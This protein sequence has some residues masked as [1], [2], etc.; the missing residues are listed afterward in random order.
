[1][2]SRRDFLKISAMA[3]AS[4]L[5]DLSSLNALS[6]AVK[7]KNRFPVAIVGAGLGGLTCGAYLAKA[8]FPVTVLEKHHVPGG[9]ASSFQRGDFDFEV[10]L[11]AIAASNNATH[12]IFRELGLLEKIELVQLE[13][14]HRLVSRGR[15]MVLPDCNPAAYIDLLAGF[16]PAEKSGI[17]GFVSEIIGIQEEVYKLFLN[18]NRYTTIL[19]PFQYPKMWGVRNQTLQNLLDDHVKDPLLQDDLSYLCGYYGLPPSRL[20]GFYYANSVADYLKNGSCYIKGRSQ[21]LSNALVEIISEN[22]GSVRLSTPV[23]RILVKKGAVAGVTT[24]GGEHVPATFVVSNASVPDTLYK[25]LGD[26]PTL[27]E[28]RKTISALRP[29]LSS[30]CVWLGLRGSL[31]KQIKGC[32]IHIACAGSMENA[33]R[34]A[35]ECNAEKTGFSVTLFDNFYPGYSAPG[36]STVMLTCLSGYEPWRIFEKDYFSGRKREYYRQKEN[37]AVTLI[38]RTEKM[39]IPGL[40]GMIIERE[41]ATP[42]TNIAYT[43]NPGGAIYGY[44]QA[45]NNQFM[46]RI[47]NSTPIEG[48]YLSSAWGYPGG[49]FTGVMRGGLR[50]SRL[51]L[52]AL[53]QLD[54]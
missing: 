53:S 21:D 23:E 51:I 35:L 28:Y 10:S 50:T 31:E 39:L 44:E 25:L 3:A 47:K 49:G 22:G 19:F 40:S 41:A 43:A 24:A 6:R 26:E 45:M 37:T 9:Y 46:G 48:L 12:K 27:S 13:R 8:G 1:M 42:L 38:R 5:A 16:F 30:F 54:G 7:D 17:E 11:H 20:S 14:S 15:D 2:I 34:Y 32:N 18:D 4:S 52:E 29:S 33:Y 36:T